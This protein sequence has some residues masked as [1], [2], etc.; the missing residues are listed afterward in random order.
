MYGKQIKHIIFLFFKFK[1]FMINKSIFLSQTVK[2]K[3]SFAL[4]FG[5]AA[6]SFI[7]FILKTKKLGSALLLKQAFAC[8]TS[9]D[10]KS[11]GYF[12][13]MLYGF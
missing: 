6:I 12:T 1:L 8:F 13:F 9:K 11:E 3:T 2:V 5:S 7:F 4:P 10:P